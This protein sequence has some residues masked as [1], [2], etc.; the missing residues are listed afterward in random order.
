MWNLTGVIIGGILPRSTGDMLPEKEYERMKYKW[1]KIIAA[2]GFLLLML[3]SGCGK[4]EAPEV[5]SLRSSTLAEIFRLMDTR[6]YRAALPLVEKYQRLEPSNEFLGELRTLICTNIAIQEAEALAQKGKLKEACAVLDDCI[7]DYGQLPGIVGAKKTYQGLQELGERIQALKEPSGSAEMLKNARWLAHY[8]AK[9]RNPQ[10]RKF[11]KAKI[12]ESAVM[13]KL[14]A[15]RAGFLI[16]ADAE[17]LLVNGDVSG[18]MALTV[19][20]SADKRYAVQTDRLLNG[21]L[22]DASYMKTEEKK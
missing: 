18:A 9:F 6:Q 7:R 12:E 20:L 1:N 3:V 13:Q 2:T 5:P 8:E 10:L 15:D 16:Y 4:K 19:L 17:T 21:G 22:F 14:E 11:A